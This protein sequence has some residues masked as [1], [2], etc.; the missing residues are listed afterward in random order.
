MANRTGDG[1]GNAPVADLM[2]KIEFVDDRGE[3]REVWVSLCPLWE[4]RSGGFNGTLAAIPTPLLGGKPVAV[5]IKMR[6]GG[7]SSDDRGRDRD[8]GR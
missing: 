1:G 3:K 2:T 7:G 8:R 6:D 5:I 4:T